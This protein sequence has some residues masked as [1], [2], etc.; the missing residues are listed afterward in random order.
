MKKFLPVAL[1][2]MS[3][4]PLAFARDKSVP[5]APGTYRQWGP[6]IDH[7]EIVQTFRLADYDNIAVVPFDTSKTPLPDP[8]DKSYDSVKSA[9]SSYTEW[10]VDALRDELKTK[11]VRLE[12]HEPKTAKTLVVRGT[13]DEISP[14]SRAKRALV[15]YGAGGSANRLSA[16]IVDA[17]SGAVLVRFSQERRSGG[18]WKFAG[19][20]DVQVMRDSI[21]AMGQD[22]AHILEQF[23]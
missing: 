2:L 23:H 8:S 18:T 16:E 1:L 13:V 12:N 4:A 22:V 6:D 19:G 14:G 20:N 11:A 5:T 9:L 7:V 15:H 10:L 17:Q 3:I 21:H